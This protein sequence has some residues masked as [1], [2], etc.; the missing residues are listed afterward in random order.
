M[1]TYPTPRAVRIS[2][3]EHGSSS[4][5]RRRRRICTS[6]DLLNIVPHACEW[7]GAA[8]PEERFSGRIDECGK[9][10]VNSPVRQVD[11]S[12]GRTCRS[13]GPDDSA[14]THESDTSLADVP[15]PTMT[16][17]TC[18]GAVLLEPLPRTILSGRPFR[19][20]SHPR[21]VPGP[22][23]RI[24]LIRARI[25]DDDHRGPWTSNGQT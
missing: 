14:P 5:F 1:K 7:P 23:T 21:R 6:T 2:A 12:S 9:Q 11:R 22:L 15:D 16:M 8:S 10:S 3:G 25:G 24:N 19:R 4:S 13:C 17:P 18:A 20:R